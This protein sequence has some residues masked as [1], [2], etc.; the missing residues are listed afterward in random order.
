M[1]EKEQ[2][3]KLYDDLVTFMREWGTTN[4]GGKLVPGVGLSAFASSIAHVIRAIPDENVR[5]GAFSG[6]IALLTEHSE[7][8]MLVTV[9]DCPT[10]AA[11]AMLAAVE[12]QGRA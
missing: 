5:K 3:I 7:V 11:D 6:V 2:A 4:A 9:L 8:S 10:M 1:T 12:P